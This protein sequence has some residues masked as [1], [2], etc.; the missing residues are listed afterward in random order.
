MK[1][2]DRSYF[3]SIENVTVDVFYRVQ[4]TKDIHYLIHGY[5]PGEKIDPDLSEKVKEAWESIT[6][7]Y[8]DQVSEGKG[9]SDLRTLAQIADME[10]EIMVVGSLIG[11]YARNESE[12]IAECLRDWKYPLDHKQSMKQLN[13]VKF[14]LSILK[15]KNKDLIE[16]EEQEE[17]KYDMYKDVVMLEQALGKNE[18]DPE[19]TVL[20]KWVKYLQVAK[21]KNKRKVKNGE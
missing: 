6:E 9:L 7:D 20:I 12:E 13:K 10:V 1:Q 3:D 15:S 18:I 14:R 5:V 4:T 16:P 17:V 21:E 8:I 11:M 2:S 19:K